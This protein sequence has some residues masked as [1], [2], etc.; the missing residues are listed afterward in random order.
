MGKSMF[1]GFGMFGADPFFLTGKER[2][3]SRKKI[4]YLKIA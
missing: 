1:G 4:K 3:R 2:S